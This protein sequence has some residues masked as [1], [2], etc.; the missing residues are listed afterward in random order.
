MNINAI[1]FGKTPV[2]KCTVKD[3]ATKKSNEA[4]V[5]KMDTMERED[6]REIQLSKNTRSIVRDFEKESY[7]RA[8]IHE[9]FLLKNDKTGEVIACAETSRHYKIGDT[10]YSGASTVIDEFSENKKYVNGAEP[11]FAYIAHN[12]EQR[13]DNYICTAFNDETIKT[14]RTHKFTQIKNGDWCMPAKRYQTVIGQAERRNNVV[15]LDSVV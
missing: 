14:L 13:Y 11:L 5:Y 3:A 7:R 12:A 1:S 4:T 6:L 10:R 8:P 9:Y 15:F 2:M